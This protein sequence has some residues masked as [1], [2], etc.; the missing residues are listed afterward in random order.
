MAILRLKQIKTKMVACD[1]RLKG[2][3]GCESVQ[4]QQF[5]MK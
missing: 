1:N 4:P 3:I 5:Y 2:P